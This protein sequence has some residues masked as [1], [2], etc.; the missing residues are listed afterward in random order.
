M[1]FTF[2]ATPTAEI[3]DAVIEKTV[4]D[5]LQ[6]E[7]MAKKV[8]EIIRGEATKFKQAVQKSMARH[9]E[10]KK[11][12]LSTPD[13][14]T[15][16]NM[17]TEELVMFR[18]T[19]KAAEAAKAQ[20]PQMVTDRLVGQAMEAVISGLEKGLKEHASAPS[21][22]PT[23]APDQA[24]VAL[25]PGAAPVS[26]QAAGA[27]MPRTKFQKAE[28]GQ[29]VSTAVGPPEVETETGSASE[30]AMPANN[31][32]QVGDRRTRDQ[33]ETDAVLANWATNWSKKTLC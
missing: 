16:V 7:T 5:L 26:G 4:K 19:C 1:K 14:T 12:D 23:A 13:M 27:L 9:L 29:A 31:E 32:A 24:A 2:T 21:A 22:T 30:T 28:N 6:D 15:L 3:E 11:A 20:A 8:L 10:M 18:D 25:M 33:I 17:T